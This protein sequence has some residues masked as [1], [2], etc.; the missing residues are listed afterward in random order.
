MAVLRLNIDD[1]EIADYHLIAIHTT[2][3]EYRLAYFINKYVSVKLQKKD[4]EIQVNSK[5]LKKTIIERF[6]FEDEKNDIFWSL[7]KNKNMIY[8]SE[9]SKENGLLINSIFNFSSE[10]YLLPELKTVDFLLKI[11]NADM[12][13]NLSKVVKQIKEIERI[14]MVYSV[15]L[16]KVKAKNNLIF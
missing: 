9:E 10:F 13:L 16:N 11:E 8:P 5:E 4:V 12:V 14:N 6:I 15:D 1:F 2:L 3:E 7:I